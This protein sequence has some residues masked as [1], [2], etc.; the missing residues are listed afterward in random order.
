[1]SLES[2]IEMLAQA[3]N[4]LAAAHRGGGTSLD[5]APK[6]LTRMEEKIEQRATEI[7]NADKKKEI[8]EKKSAEA[9]TT[10]KSSKASAP[11]TESSLPEPTY[12][13]VKKLILA[14]SAKSR[15]KVVALLARYGAKKGPDLKEDQ[16][17]LFVHEGNLVLSGDLDPEAG[18]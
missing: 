18:A 17:A 16:Y 5:V 2:S 6:A 13:D 8:G 1:M 12:D 9:P 3:I 7:V 10:D 11:T 15:D 4:E 14:I